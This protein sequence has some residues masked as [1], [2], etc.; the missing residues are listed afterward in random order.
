MKRLG[1]GS[2]PYLLLAPYATHFLVITAFPVVFSLVLTLH[3][4]NLLS[5]MQWIG[6]LNF[7]TLV[8]DPLFWKALWN[9]F[10][11]L[12]V[13]VPLQVGLSLV[14]AALL[15][16]PIRA[17]GFFRAAFFLPVVLSGVVITIMWKQLY[18]SETG[19]FNAL[20]ALMG[21]GRVGWLTD[22]D[23]AMLSIAIMATWKNMGLY[24]ILLLAGLQSIPKS[25]Y[26]AASIDGA[27][28]M[29]QFTKITIPLLNPI[30]MSV[31]ILSTIN[32]FSLFIE[33]YVMTGGGPLNSTLS[34][35]LYIYRQAFS[36]Y[37][38]GYAATLGFV[39]AAVIFVVV[40][41]QRR[42]LE[43]EVG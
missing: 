27:G 43:R 35:N 34:M 3:R 36:F 33:P 25:V 31:I 19:V 5:P 4:W 1:A 42:F 15:N 40:V 18:S 9:T 8:H 37:K 12:M 24:V 28:E 29:A 26:E 32:G 21:L 22:P 16:Q 10:K 11:F 39:L 30:L 23:I 14:L 13:H 20:L 38:M 7:T 6:G 2:S 41:L 17:R